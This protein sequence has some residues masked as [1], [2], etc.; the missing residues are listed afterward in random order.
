LIYLSD[1]EFEFLKLKRL[2]FLK[3]GSDFYKEPSKGGGRV[4][5]KKLSEALQPTYF[6][7]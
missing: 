5:K 1:E 4:I 3:R 2:D 6:Y 7:T